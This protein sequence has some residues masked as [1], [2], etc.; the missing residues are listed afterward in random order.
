M[1]ALRLAL[2]TRPQWIEGPL[3]TPSEG[4]DPRILR[5]P[6]Q[7]LVPLGSSLA[8]LRA[9]HQQGAGWL[10][11]TSPSSVEAFYISLLEASPDRPLLS[12]LRL[13]AVGGG[14]KDRLSLLLKA[15]R[16]SQAQ[17]DG[18]TLADKREL[19]DA[20]SLLA[21][22]AELQR[23]EGFD[24]SNQTVLLVTAVGNRP[25]LH[26]GLAAWGAQVTNLVLYERVD[27]PWPDEAVKARM[28]AWS[29][30]ETAVVVTST[31]VI[32]RM[33]EQLREASID[34]ASLVWCT[35]HQRI[36]ERL[37]GLVTSKVRQ[38]RL[39]PEFLT[40]DLFTHETYW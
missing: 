33:F 6:I 34:S 18:A 14:T 36:A 16:I 37:Q 7:G 26:D 29:A 10:L 9:V 19:A 32:P 40:E 23:Q 35:Q 31:T 25:R 20:E 28:T 2:L 38:V 17:L 22:L 4:H 30:Q 5:A 13:I 8:L 12:N 21:T 3:A 39:D 24:W 15:G 11:F 27:L 1:P